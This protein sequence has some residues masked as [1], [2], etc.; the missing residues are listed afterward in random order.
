MVAVLPHLVMCI[1]A[2]YILCPYK[3]TT[4]GGQPTSPCE[5]RFNQPIAEPRFA[6]AI[7]TDLQALQACYNLPFGDVAAK[8]GFRYSAIAVGRMAV[9]SRSAC[10]TIKCRNKLNPEFLTAFMATDYCAVFSHLYRF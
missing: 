2:P 1:P 3:G 8:L 9:V 6:R 5:I 10:K 7:Q 4:Y